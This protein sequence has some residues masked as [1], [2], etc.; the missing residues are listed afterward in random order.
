MEIK[1]IEKQIESIL[2]WKAEPVKISELAK[3]LEISVEQVNEAAASL[4]SNLENRGIQLLNNNNELSLITS[5][6]NGPLIEK[7]LKEE[8]NKELSKAALETLSIILYKGPMKRS[9]IDY[10]RGVNSQF[11]IRNLMIR[12]LVDKEQNPN[13]ERGFFYKASADLLNFM[14]I[15]SVSEMP[16]YEKVRTDIDT[17]MNNNEEAKPETINPETA[18]SETTA[19]SESADDLTETNSETDDIVGEAEINNSPEN[20][21]V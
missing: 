13:D 14:G 1:T 5:A 9:E 21:N 16:E 19:V 20:N 6:E 2:F 8:L 10:I 3:I 17:F 4:N 18:N 12:G 15:K 11:I 7:L